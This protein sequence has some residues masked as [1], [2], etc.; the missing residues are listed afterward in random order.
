[1]KHWMYIIPALL[2]VR[3]PLSGAGTYPNGLVFGTVTC[4][5]PL[6]EAEL[7]GPQGRRVRTRRVIRL[8]TNPRIQIF[9]LESP[10]EGRWRVRRLVFREKQY[11]RTVRLEI[12]FPE[13]A[14]ETA[15]S[16]TNRTVSFGHLRFFQPPL[17]RL[18]VLFQSSASV[19]VKRFRCLSG[20][21]RQALALQSLAPADPDSTEEAVLFSLIDRYPGLSDSLNA[22]RNL[23]GNR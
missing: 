5:I 11:G 4:S 6:A 17:E 1:M 18:P 22:M 7:S 2:L 16:A 19:K 23:R 13:D 8:K 15:A 14:P 10:P 20:K 12:R 9:L 21:N 3:I